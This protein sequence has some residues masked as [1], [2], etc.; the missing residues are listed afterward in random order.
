MARVMLRYEP[1]SDHGRVSVLPPGPRMPGPLQTLWYT[2]DQPGFWAQCRQ[3]FGKTFTMRLPGFPPVVVTSDR[4]AV[5]RLLTGDPLLRRHGNDLLRP[6]FGDRSLLL[7]EPAEH[8]ARRRIELPPFHGAAVRGYGDRVRELIEGELATWRDGEIIASHPR[9]RWL[10]LEVILELVLGVR[11]PALRAE[12]GQIIDWFNTP[13]NNLAMF[14]PSALNQRASWNLLTRP[15]YARLDRLHELLTQHIEQTQRDPAVEERSD[16]LAMLVQAR[17]EEGRSLSKEDLRDELVTLVIAGHETTATAIA[18]ACDLLAHNPQVQVELREAVASG[19][20]EYVRAA[21]KEVLR[22]RTLAYASAARHS[23]EPFEIGEWVIGPEAAI[24]VDAQGIHGDPELHPEPWAF[25][26][27]R[28]IDKTPDGYSY[29]PFG[30]GAHRCLG[31]ALAMLELELFL[32]V[33]GGSARVGAAGDPAR[34]VRRGVTLV[35]S[36]EGRVRVTRHADRAARP[37][38]AVVASAG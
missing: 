35:P 34:A 12:L 27:E 6:I 25:R 11:D 13:L 30:G 2:M 24:I 10:T 21:A 3:R 19:E 29:I 15:A 5:R 37:A 23:L 36:N 1:D 33:L 16:V 4:D 32:E 26:P 31:A 14:L 18:W 28:F 38:P 7:L 22:A 8:L 17:D 9:A 20:G